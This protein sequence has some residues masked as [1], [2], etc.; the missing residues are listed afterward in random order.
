MAQRA[1]W[2][3]LRERE[4]DGMRWLVSDFVSVGT[5]M[6]CAD[7]LYTKT[8]AEWDARVA[9]REL[10]TCPPEADLAEWHKGTTRL[11]FTYPSGDRRVIYHAAP[12]APV[13]WTNLWFPSRLGVFGDWFG[14]PLAPLF[15][16]GVRDIPVTARGMRWFPALAHTKYFSYAHDVRPNSPTTR[17]R[18]ALDLGST[19]WLRAPAASPAAHERSADAPMRP[20]R[21]RRPRKQVSE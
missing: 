1:L 19:A 11:W 17:L 4:S 15:G 9:R 10:P 5:P 16:P 8:R 20:R 7:V 18:A 2:M 14:G 12:F 13:R 21:Q 6:Y 3:N